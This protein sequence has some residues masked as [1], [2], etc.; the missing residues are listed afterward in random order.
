MALKASTRAMEEWEEYFAQNPAPPGHSHH[1]G[2]ME[3]FCQRHVGHHPI[4]LVTSGGTTVPLER[5]TVRFVDNF[6]AGTRGA[7]STEYFLQQGYAVIFIH[8]TSPSLPSCVTSTPGSYWR[9]CRRGRA[10]CCSSHHNTLARCIPSGVS[11]SRSRLGRLLWLTFTSLSDYLWLLRSATQCL[12]RLAP[13]A[14]LYLA[15]AVS[16]FY[17]PQD[18]ISEHKIQSESGPLTVRLQLVPKMLRP[19]VSVWGPELYVVSFK[20]ET[21]EKKLIEKAT[22]ALRKYKHD[23]VIGNLLQTRRDEVT[24]VTERESSLLRLTE[25]QKAERIEIER[26]IVEEVCS[27]HRPERGHAIPLAKL[28]H[29]STMLQDVGRL[30]SHAYA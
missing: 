13:K 25:H 28:C 19:L 27:R 10:A 22:A 8:A 16:D 21:D 24:L 12:Q 11:T 9:P 1:C 6:S 23:L 14:L 18:E 26:L 2:D 20:L 17:I 29:P 7:A 15:A 3:A 5:N 4:A 30:L